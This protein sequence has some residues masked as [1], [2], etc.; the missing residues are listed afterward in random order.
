MENVQLNSPIPLARPTQQA[1][2][3]QANGREQKDAP[4]KNAEQFSVDKETRMI[5][6]LSRQKSAAQ[7][8]TLQQK[9]VQ[10]V[11]RQGN[12]AST[13]SRSPQPS[14]L[15]SSRAP[16]WSQLSAAVNGYTHLQRAMNLYQQ[17]ESL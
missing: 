5:A 8:E 17:I 7:Q 6:E 2:S 15:S 14:V 4:E 1:V 11:Q 9:N 3:A 16:N 12:V 13:T 10:E